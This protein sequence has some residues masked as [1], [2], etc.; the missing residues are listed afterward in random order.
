MKTEEV[1]K[2]LSKVFEGYI[3]HRLFIEELFELLNN[4]LKGKEKAF[5]KCLATQLKYIKSFGVMVNTADGHEKVLGF[6]GHYYSIHIEQSQFNVRFLVHIDDDGTPKF[7]C[8]FY[9]RSGHRRTSYDEYTDV[10]KQRFNELQG[11][12][13]NE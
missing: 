6:D 13:D 12:E 2:L 5:F 7:L 3:F 11:D 9:E 4:N 10:L 8:A 1:L